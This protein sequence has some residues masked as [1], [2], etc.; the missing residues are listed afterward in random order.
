M[1]YDYK[2]INQRAVDTVEGKLQGG[3]PVAVITCKSCVTSSLHQFSHI[4]R[5]VPLYFRGDDANSVL[6]Y[7][8]YSVANTP[9]NGFPR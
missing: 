9:L 4:R 2:H 5:V 7:D 6:K 8:V 1:W 3:T